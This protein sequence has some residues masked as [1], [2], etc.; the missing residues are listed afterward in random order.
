MRIALIMSLI[1]LSLVGYSLPATAENN[2][3]V[4]VGGGVN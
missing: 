4:K 3:Y 1:V 2:W